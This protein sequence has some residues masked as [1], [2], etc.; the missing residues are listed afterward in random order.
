M[1][2]LSGRQWSEFGFWALF[3]LLGCAALTW[4]VLSIVWSERA[5]RPRGFE[6]KTNV[7][8]TPALREKENDHG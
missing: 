4:I 7:G 1:D 3:V 5:K 6:M 2:G 8:E